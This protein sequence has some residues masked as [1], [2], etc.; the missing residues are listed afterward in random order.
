MESTGQEG[1]LKKSSPMASKVF[2]QGAKVNPSFPSIYY[3]N[4][5]FDQFIKDANQRFDF[6]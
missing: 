6:R 2:A 5:I 3:V 1:R 4:L